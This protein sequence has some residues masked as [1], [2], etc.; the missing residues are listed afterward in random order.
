MIRC[1]ET[2]CRDLSASMK[3]EWLGTNGLGGFA[4]ASISGINTWR[5]HGLLVASNRPPVGRMVL[6]S[7]FEETLVVDGLRYELSANRYPGVVHPQ[8]YL[9]LKEFRQDPFPVFVYEIEGL[10][11]EKSIFMV[12]GENTNGGSVCAPRCQRQFLHIRAETFDRV[13]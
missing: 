11:L 3:R 13:P 5:Y 6:L 4:S 12:H 1:D 10:Q 2:I 8:G 9:Y 7:K